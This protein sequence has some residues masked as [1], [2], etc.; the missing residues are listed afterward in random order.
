MSL[1]LELAVVPRYPSRG[2][3]GWTAGR[4]L[5]WASGVP[6]VKSAWLKYNKK[7]L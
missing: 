7:E 2:T 3:S 1:A 6:E 4:L 5:S